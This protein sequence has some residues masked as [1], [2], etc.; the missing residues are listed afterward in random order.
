MERLD[1]S[2]LKSES[3]RFHDATIKVYPR[4]LPLDS[5][6]YWPENGRTQFSFSVLEQQKGLP[7]YKI[8][9]SEITEFVAAE[10]VHALNSLAD[11]IAR[12][13]IQQ[14]LVVTDSGKLLDGN[15]RFFA[16]HWLSQRP[17]RR[18]QKEDELKLILDEIPV[19]IIRESDL[20]P[21]LELKILAE[22]NFVKDLRVPWPLT[23]KAKA[24]KSY[25]ELLT[26]ERGIDDEAA[27]RQIVSVLSIKKPE[28]QQLLGALK[29]SEEF[30]D[31]GK[32]NEEK[33]DR[34][35]ISEERLVYFWEFYNKAIIGRSRYTDD[36]QLHE[37]KTVFFELMALGS[38]SPLKNVK[39]VEPFSA[40][41]RDKIAWAMVNESKTDNLPLVV[42]YMNEKKEKRKAED[43][44]RLFCNWLED[45]DELTPSASNQLEKLGV[46][47][48]KKLDRGSE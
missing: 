20:T 48:I 31:G 44:I 13:G 15:R 39:Q 19:Y 46:L 5:I 34:G 23:A 32:S 21:E 28:A 1:T 35:R 40:S 29:L 17:K 41:R 9:I 26:E 12:N 10:K 18:N 11:S 3:K 33:I 14:P 37:V 4:K 42:N 47:I 25:Y 24:I 36:I 45:V 30:I 27:M 16:C 38:R 8:P 7:I 6:T 22:A 43:K 2:S